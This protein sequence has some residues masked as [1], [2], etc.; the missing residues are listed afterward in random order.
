M[1][2]ALLSSLATFL[3]ALMLPLFT[4]SWSPVSAGS[5]PAAGQ[6]LA[7]G[8]L[9]SE[10]DLA[11]VTGGC[12]KNCGSSTV[13]VIG[14]EWVPVSQVDGPAQQLSYSI[15]EEYSNVY[16]SKPLTYEFRSTNACRHVFI[17]GGAGIAA[18]FNVSIGTTYHCSVNTTLAG[19]ID[20]GYRVKI[21]R[22]DMRMLS[23]LT[24]AEYAVWSDGRREPTGGTDTGRRERSWY[25]FTPVHAKGN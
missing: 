6:L 17:S 22:G 12:R 5:L 16:G 25:R 11:T 15:V 8:S 1:N 13:R 18:G 3:L 2:R 21:Y 24:V 14:T 23:T 20:P 19:T 4:G 10:S 7:V 9:V